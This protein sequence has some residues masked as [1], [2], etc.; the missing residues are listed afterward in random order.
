MPRPLGSRR[1]LIVATAGLAIAIVAGSSAAAFAHYTAKDTPSSA[2]AADVGLASTGGGITESKF[3]A[4]TPCRLVDTRL[5]GGA[6]SAGASRGFVAE[7]VDLASQGG[8]SGGCGIPHSANAIEA[9]ITAVSPAGAGFLRVFPGGEPEPVATFLTYA[10]NNIGNMGTFKI[11]MDAPLDFTVKVHTHKTQVL[12]D[13]FGYYEPPIAAYVGATAALVSEKS[14]RAVSAAR[15]TGY[16]HGGYNVTFDRNVSSCL[17]T[18]LPYSGSAFVRAQ[19]LS[20]FPNSVLVL[21][22][23]PSNSA[24]YIDVSFHITVTC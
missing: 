24:V 16:T 7:G 2:Q 18:V 20:G 8:K 9:T 19:P 10:N 15:A 4:I 17:Y 11:N 14:S 22:T 23:Q 5:A 12:V 13:V 6:I 1:R 3:V 21:T